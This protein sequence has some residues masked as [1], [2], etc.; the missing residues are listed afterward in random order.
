MLVKYI[1]NIY[2]TNLKK[3]KMKAS[4]AKHVECSEI[5]LRFS[6][7]FKLYDIPDDTIISMLKNIDNKLLKIYEFYDLVIIRNVSDDAILKVKITDENK[8]QIE[9]IL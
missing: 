3:L 5:F 2:I 4:I 9:N 7:G 8:Y 6:D 1:N